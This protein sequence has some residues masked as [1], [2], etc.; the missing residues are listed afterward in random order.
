MAY[1]EAAEW[2]YRPE[3]QYNQSIINSD[4]RIKQLQ[5][6]LNE[7]KKKGSMA[8][9]RK[10]QNEFQSKKWDF[11]DKIENMIVKIKKE[12]NSGTYEKIRSEYEKRLESIAFQHAMNYSNKTGNPRLAALHRILKGESIYPTLKSRRNRNR[13]KSRNR[14]PHKPK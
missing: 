10:N 2:N 3:K 7:I 11:E 5:S 1:N 4:P 6:K 8:V 12:M 9:T 14:S 13:N